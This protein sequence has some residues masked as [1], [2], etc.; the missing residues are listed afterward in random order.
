MEIYLIK[1]YRPAICVEILLSLAN[2]LVESK[3]RF[4][5]AKFS[6][7]LVH[8][9]ASEAFIIEVNRITGPLVIPS[10]INLLFIPL[11][12]IALHPSKRIKK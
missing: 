6:S 1:T 10:A 7:F 5:V 2:L 3:E 9:R 12:S 8:K 4:N 11:L